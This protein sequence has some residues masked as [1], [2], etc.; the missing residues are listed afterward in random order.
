VD[1]TDVAWVSARDG[2]R[3]PGDLE[4]QAARYQ[5]AR[6]ELTINADFRAITDLTAH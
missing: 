4:D 1:L 6:H 5:S 2:S 3:A